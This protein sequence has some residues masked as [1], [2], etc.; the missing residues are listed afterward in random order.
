MLHLADIENDPDA[1]ATDIEHAR[2]AGYRTSTLGKG[3]TLRT[4]LPIGGEFR[5]AA[6]GASPFFSL[7]V[8]RAICC[9]AFLPS[10]DKDLVQ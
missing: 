10:A 8:I 3:S 7:K 2:L 1:A 5:K 9:V 6:P 4:G